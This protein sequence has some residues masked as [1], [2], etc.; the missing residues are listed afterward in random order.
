MKRLTHLLVPILVL[1]GYLAGQIGF[2]LSD[3]T[4]PN[5]ATYP[6]QGHQC[7]CTS[8]DHCW[9]QCCCM[10]LSERLAWA[11]RH[12][13]SP[14][15]AA[16]HVQ[17]AA[18]EDCH[19]KSACC[20]AMQPTATVHVEKLEHVEKESKSAFSFVLT[21]RAMNCRGHSSHWFASSD[22]AMATR[23]SASGSFE[24]PPHGFISWTNESFE[25]SS[26]RPPVPPG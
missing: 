25:N 20:A 12:R 14:P 18:N 19:S 3:G 7:G 6:C 16:S 21:I 26:I 24:H 9:Q 1:V 8:A 13:V 4:I 17:L 22:P 10:S 5:G 11:K 23:L 15:A 2:P